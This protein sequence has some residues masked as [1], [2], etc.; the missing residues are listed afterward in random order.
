MLVIQGGSQHLTFGID[1]GPILSTKKS[2]IAIFFN[3][4]IIR[5]SL[6]AKEGRSALKRNVDGENSV[7]IYPVYVQIN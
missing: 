6:K 7:V 5:V 1:L 3:V 2:I 4:L